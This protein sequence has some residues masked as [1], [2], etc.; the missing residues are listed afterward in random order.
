MLLLLLLLLAGIISF[1][2]VIFR[3]ISVFLV[4]KGCTQP[5]LAI[6]TDCGLVATGTR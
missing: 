3:K 6:D 2:N 4:W 1:Q 5:S